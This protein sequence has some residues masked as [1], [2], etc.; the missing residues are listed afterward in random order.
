[1]SEIEVVTAKMK[2]RQKIRMALILVSFFLFPAT[3]YYLSP[4]LIIQAAS[5]GTING[6]FIMFA[7]LFVSSLV[8]GRAFCGWVCPGAGCQEAI[9]QANDRRVSRGDFI[10]WAIWIPWIGIIVTL[11]VRRGGYEKVD[12]F[13]E[14]FYGLSISNAQGLIAY[15]IVLLVL[16]VLPAFAVGRRSFCHH[17]CWMAP[18]MIL[19]RKVRNLSGWP[20]LQLTAVTERCTHCHTCTENCPMSLPVEAMVEGGLMENAECILC[21]SC[22]DGCEFDALEY[23]FFQP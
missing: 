3:F 23:S 16:I 20:S 21:G 7:L 22:I 15:L 4:V 8:L 1:V 9:F 6:S 14:T 13:Y 10:K 11:V 2:T 17:L 18:F 12:F 5:E 19:G